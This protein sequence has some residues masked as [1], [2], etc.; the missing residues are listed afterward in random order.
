VLTVLG[1]VDTRRHSSAA[2]VRVLAVDGDSPAYR[3]DPPCHLGDG[4]RRDRVGPVADQLGPAGGGRLAG[5]Q[6]GKP[7]QRSLPATA[8]EEAALRS[9]PG[10]GMPGPGKVRVDPEPWWWVAGQPRRADRRDPR[11][12]VAL[13]VLSEPPLRERQVGRSAPG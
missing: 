4:R 9:E 2:A 13:Q 3:A 6:L 8:L 12:E 1:A 5:G 7:R 11:P 10:A